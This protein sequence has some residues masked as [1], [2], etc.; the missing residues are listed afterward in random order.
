MNKWIGVD[1]DGTLAHYRTGQKE[2]GEPIEPM[3]KRVKEWHEMGYEVR[4]VTARVANISRDLIDFWN[5]DNQI[6]LIREWCTKHLGFTLMP[7]S[8]KDFMMTELWDDR[9]VQVAFNKGER[10]YEPLGK[11]VYVL[12]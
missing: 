8:E 6:K 4:I 3:V 7:T 5:R 12:S 2:I 10:L 11:T 9:A 1:L